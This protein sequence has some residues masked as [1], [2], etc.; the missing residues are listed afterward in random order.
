[1]VTPELAPFAYVGGLGDVV[2]ALPKALALRGHDVRILMPLY[3]SIKPQPD[4]QS[5]EAPFVIHLGDG[6]RAYAKLWSTYLSGTQVQVYLIEHRQYF[7]RHEIY[8]GPWGSHGDNNERFTV[9]S[10][11]AIDLC[12]FIRW[13]PDIVHCHDWTTGLVPVY[14]NTTERGAPLGKVASVMTIHNLEHQGVFGRE[15]LSFTGIPESEFRSDS[16]ESCGAVNMLKGGL[17]HATKITTVSPTYAT[18]IRGPMG[19]CGLNEVLAFRGADLVGILNG[20]DTSVWD[21]KQDPYLPATYDEANFNEKGKCKRALQEQFD[22]EV[23]PNVM[24]VGVVSRLYHQK[25]I[26]LLT[27][28]LPGLMSEMKLQVVILGVGEKWLED[29]LRYWASQYPGRIGVEIGYNARLSHLIMAGADTFC[30]P[31]RFEPCGLTQLYAMR[32]GTLPVARATGGL[33]DTVE[34]YDEATQQGTGFLFSEPSGSGLY[35][36]IGWACATYYDKPEVFR[37]LQVQAMRK[38]FSWAV[39]AS[40]YEEVYKWAIDARS[41]S[42]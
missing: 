2:G 18:E 13:Q 8:S 16:L 22:L 25:G 23:D 31:S 3:G 32:Y 12:P 14:L 26:D 24:V 17:Y 29:A 11:A 19:G 34:Q 40:K 6:R 42:V 41:T 37:R 7:E 5:V 27:E 28:I 30:M 15:I 35:Y 4:W 33:C 38:D 1:M 9:L 39:S 10:R 36:T 21:P 20:I